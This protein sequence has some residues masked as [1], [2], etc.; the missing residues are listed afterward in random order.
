M[1]FLDF[2]K[3]NTSDR[4]SSRRFIGL[5]G[6]ISLAVC[7]ISDVFF[8]LTAS[9]FLIDALIWII[10]IAMAATTTSTASANISNKNALNGRDQASKTTDRI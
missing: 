9:E 8:K 7:I 4:L 10:G 3:E 2:F 6:F 1:N 5:T